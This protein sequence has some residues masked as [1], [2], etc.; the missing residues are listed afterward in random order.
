M[1][2]IAHTQVTTVGLHAQGVK[3]RLNAVR[4]RR[5]ISTC[6]TW[7]SGS[8]GNAGTSTDPS[9]DTRYRVLQ[10]ALWRGDVQ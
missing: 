1:L 10:G 4:F 7:E 2:R 9:A 6:T 3:S 8:E 5:S